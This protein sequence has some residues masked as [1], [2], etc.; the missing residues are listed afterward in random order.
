MTMKTMNYT[1]RN[2]LSLAWVIVGLTDWTALAT[3]YTNTIAQMTAYITNQMAGRNVQGLSIALVD[4]QD[5]VWV[6]GFGSADRE[7]GVAADA[8]TVYHI[9]SCSKAFTGTAL[10]Q[11]WDQGRLDLEAPLTTYIPEFSMLPRFTHSEPVTIRSLLNH[12][13]GL[14]GD[15]FNGLFTTQTR[16]DYNDWLIEYL[17]EDYPVAPVNER[18]SYCNTGFILLDEVVRR[19][20][21]TPFAAATEAMIF[22]PLG[23]SATSFLPDKPAISNRLAAAYNPIGERQPDEIVN[24][25]GTG[26]MYSSANDLTKYIRM[27]LADGRFQG[28]SLISS[29]AIEIM[30]TPQLANLPLNVSDSPS[31]LG[32]DVVSD[33]QLRYAGRVFWKD[34]AT[35]FHCA[36]L[37]ISRDL[38]LGVAVIQ[39]SP[40]NWC[41]EIGIEALRWTI[42][43]KQGIP[44]PTNTFVPPLS[45]V[46]NRLQ[47]ELNA[48]AGLYVADN[49][50]HKVVAEPGALTA[51]LK[52][53]SSTPTVLSN[54]VPRANGWFSSPDSQ[55]IQLAFTNLAGHDM[56]VAHL[57]NDSP[58]ES[59]GLLGE[60]F[61]PGSLS[62]AWSSR[63]NRVYRVVDMYPSDILWS[64]PIQKTLRLQMSDGVLLNEWIL[65]QSIMEPQNDTVAFQ[66]GVSYRKGGAL[67]VFMTN[68][69]EILQHA[70]FRYIDEA[71]IPT[72]SVPAATNGSIPFANGTQWYGFTGQAGNLYRFSLTAPGQ[73]CFVRIT[74]REGITLCEGSQAQA[75]WTC[76]SNGVYSV[77]VSATHTFTFTASLTAN[78]LPVISSISIDRGTNVVLTFPTI[79]GATYQM[80]GADALSSTNWTEVSTPITG[81]GSSTN[82]Q[83]SVI[84]PQRFY[85]LRAMLP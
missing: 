56:L 50:Y 8:D 38:Q 9:G 63:T 66:R 74:D 19:I 79:S 51:I 81:N 52:A 46:T 18:N 54:L 39:N 77:A 28:Q 61:V 73:T 64:M 69:Y 45:P 1:M 15:F 10:M 68:G 72:L 4:G 11:L 44:W 65:N 41:D 7:H 84:G 78:P 75:T 40:G 13:S 23:M 21:S 59:V 20:T 71:A 3:T 43:D 14:P 70:S 76:T 62:P 17:Q 80:Y 31:G 29:N 26:S 35:L 55:A 5:V 12:H 37:G 82:V 85:R 34:G 48:L 58:Y 25:L 57:S 33:P 53:H 24:G 27:I 32:W 2:G 16:N 30:T 67:R 22:S 36:F 6:T 47:T 83:H 60:R 42:L 49:G